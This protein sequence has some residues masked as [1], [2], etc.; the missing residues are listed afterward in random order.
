MKEKL[1]K[2]FEIFV[3][4]NKTKRFYR[5]ECKVLKWQAQYEELNAKIAKSQYE[6][7]QYTIQNA[8]T[9][10]NLKGQDNE[11]KNKKYEPKSKKQ[12]KC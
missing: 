5:R 12:G 6:K 10:N 8:I 7:M 1:K 4:R 2:W 9:I 3:L 11:K